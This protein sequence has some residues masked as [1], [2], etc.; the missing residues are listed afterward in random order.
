MNLHFNGIV[1]RVKEERMKSLLSTFRKFSQ[2]TL[3][4]FKNNS[5]IKRID[6]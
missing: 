1:S 2:M 3:L 5:P 4:V 6:S